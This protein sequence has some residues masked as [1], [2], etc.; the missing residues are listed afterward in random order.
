MKVRFVSIVLLLMMSLSAGAENQKELVDQWREVLLYGIDSEIM[1]TLGALRT[2]GE[3]SL[4]DELLQL[5]R[6]SINTEIR[7]AILQYYRETGYS[8]AAEPVLAMLAMLSAGDMEDS[9]L[10]IGLVRYFIDVRSDESVSVLINLLG[11]R[12]QGVALAAI[13][14]LGRS[15]NSEAGAAI[16]AKL[17]DRE[18]PAEL[19]PDLILALGSLGYA[20]AY[21]QLVAIIRDRGGERIERLYACDALGKIGDSRAVDELKKLFGEADSLVKMYAASA[22]ANFSMEEVQDLLIQGL[23]D[24]NPRVRITSAKALADPGAKKAV[25]ILIYKVEND[26][27]KA[28]RGEAIRSLGAIG[29]SRAIDYLKELYLSET[30]T[31]SDREIAL[32]ALTDNHLSFSLKAVETLINRDYEAKNQA[33]LELT[34]KK[35]AEIKSPQLKSLYER[36]LESVNPSLRIY[37]LRGIGKNGF[38]EFRADIEE[39]SENDPHP[40]VR[41]IAAAVLNT[42]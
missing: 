40:A 2:A 9:E 16:E 41:Q 38:R 39:L 35:L 26:P 18:Y 8:A 11:H 42:L 10:M 37:A 17:T 24:S 12:D 25:D 30:N 27:E 7:L 5:F 23:R 32:I 34:A 15:E 31:L 21:D 4:D 28:V 3:R 6:E 13:T 14:A 29:G 33:A 1:A 22:L 20:P 19:R 36:F